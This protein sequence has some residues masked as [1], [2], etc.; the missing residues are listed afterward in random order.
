[1][2]TGKIRQERKRENETAKAQVT[3]DSTST[4]NKKK[5]SSDGM[6]LLKSEASSNLAHGRGP[7]TSS[8][9]SRQG[10]FSDSS[11]PGDGS[12]SKVYEGDRKK[13]KQ[14]DRRRLQAVKVAAGNSVNWFGYG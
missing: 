14:G 6:E 13:L 2:D 11:S 8:G 1:M 7:S 4:A 12:W 10:R 3:L 9:A 5:L